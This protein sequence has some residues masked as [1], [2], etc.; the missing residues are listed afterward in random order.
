MLLG[1]C[2]AFGEGVNAADSV[3]GMLRLQF[4]H[5]SVC[6]TGVQD[7]GTDQ[8][9]LTFKRAVNEGLLHSGSVV[10]L[11]T[12]LDNFDE[13]RTRGTPPYDKPFFT[14]APDGS[15]RPHEAPAL[16]RFLANHS[17]AYYQAV[18][19]LYGSGWIVRS[20]KGDDQMAAALYCRLV[21][22]IQSVAA[23][24]HVRL[25]MVYTSGKF[26][27]HADA[28]KRSTAA[29]EC[30]NRHG[31]TFVNLDEDARE[32]EAL[33]YLRGGYH[34][35]ELGNRTAYEYLNEK[36]FSRLWSPSS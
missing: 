26:A 34:W 28:R 27:D 25:V 35:N 8:Q 14:L 10:V 22:E 5:L 33:N 11:M 31:I 29:A 18:L 30:A 2:F 36:L 17:G 16:K 24:A 12:Y 15:L 6:N 13:I 1:D 9:L 32:R 20:I 3:A 23:A 4:P 19:H 7:Y 21:A